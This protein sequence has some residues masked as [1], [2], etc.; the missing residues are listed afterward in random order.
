MV[1]CT[2]SGIMPELDD[3]LPGQNALVDDFY[4]GK[5]PENQGHRS[6]LLIICI[7]VGPYAISMP[8]PQTG[9]WVPQW[10]SGA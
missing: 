6:P 5:M 4:T 8:C 3:F 10:G 9:A 2:I 7:V 1:P